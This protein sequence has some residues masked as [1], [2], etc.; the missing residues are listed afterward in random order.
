M[1]GRKGDLARFRK[2]CREL[3]LAVTHQREAIYNLLAAT[4]LHPSPETIYATVRRKIPSISLGTVYKNIRVFIDAGLV[5]EVSPLHETLRLDAN[6]APH[7]HL[8]CARCKKVDDLPEDG[9]EPVRFRGRLPKGFQL[10]RTVVE[11]IGLC[12]ACAPK[13]IPETRRQQWQV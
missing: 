13:A 8:V 5:R 4:D 3:G 10:Q 7:H 12:A 11:V 9:V 6:L 2:R 1:D